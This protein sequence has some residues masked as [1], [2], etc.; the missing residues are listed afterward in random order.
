MVANRISLVV[1]GISTETIA[2]EAGND[3]KN[4]TA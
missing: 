4:D 2:F 1:P 3:M